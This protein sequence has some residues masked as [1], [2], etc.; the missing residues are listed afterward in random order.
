MYFSDNNCYIMQNNGKVWIKTFSILYR[1]IYII[2]CFFTVMK[3]WGCAI[4]KLGLILHAK[5]L[6]FVKIN[7]NV[8]IKYLLMIKINRKIFCE[9]SYCSLVRSRVYCTLNIY[10]LRNQY[11]VTSYYLP[12]AQVGCTEIYIRFISQSNLVLQST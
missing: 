6:C 7:Q 1:I 11:I 12:P 2:W 5:I 9:E 3:Y 4:V 10:H 8:L